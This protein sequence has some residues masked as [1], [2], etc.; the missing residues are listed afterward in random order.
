M[1]GTLPPKLFQKMKPESWRNRAGSVGSLGRIPSRTGFA[2]DM[3]R[4]FHLLLPRWIQLIPTAVLLLATAFL[5]TSCGTFSS[6]I[7]TDPKPAVTRLQSGGGIKEEV[8]R[9]V[10]PLLE[11]KE[12]Y[13][14]V[15]GVLTPN[16]ATQVHGFGGTGRPGETNA[17]GGDDIFEVGSLAKLFVAATLA[18]LVEE[19][20]L[21]YEDSLRSIFPT[22]VPLSKD[23]GELTLHELV[24]HTGG[25]P[26][27]PVGLDQLS[28]FVGFLFTGHNLYSYVDKARTYEFLRKCR[29]KPRDMRGYNYS[30]F[31]VGLLA[32][33]MEVRTGRSFPDLMEEKICRPLNLRDT[34]FALNASQQKR[35]TVGHVGDQPRFKWRNT[36]MEPW[37]MGE[38]MRAT[39]GLYS[40][41]NDLLIF[42]K[43]SLGRLHHPLESCLTSTQRIQLKRPEEDV[44]LG[45]LIN[46]FDAGRLKITYKH[47]MV[48]G[49]NAYLGMNAD[50]GLA[51]VV[52]YS[53]FNWNE[54]VGH[55]LVLRLSDGLVTQSAEL[56][57]GK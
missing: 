47:G 29:L 43:A 3:L 37:D 28:S 45:W 11:S 40:T 27:E 12:V 38:I 34:V 51:V 22:N 39:G 16:G 20:T 44:A 56:T 10:Q 5:S 46:Y 53:N 4:A 48:A 7:V 15:V 24:T 25:L 26:R 32:H 42:A 52:L 1:H 6:R 14:A 57:P 49:Y 30:N 41:A 36:P 8:D 33:V 21:R 13:S 17:P 54:K 31:G 35:L 19:G 2:P 55:N 18:K 23:A 50:K 9:L